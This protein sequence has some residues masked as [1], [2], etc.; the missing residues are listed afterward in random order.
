M[1]RLRAT[2]FL[3]AVGLL[4]LVLVAH[5]EPQPLLE[6]APCPARPS[7]AYHW[8]VKPFD[9]Q[10]P[11]RGAFGDPR[12]LALDQPFGETGPTASGSYE[13]H[14]G[15]DIV[16]YHA[17]VYP[18]VSGEVGRID[19]HGI[20]VFSS[21]G[22]EFIYEH[23]LGNVVI[24]QQVVAGHTVLGWTHR[25]LNHVHFG[26]IDV[27][28]HRYQ[29]ALAPGHLEPYAD[30]TTPRAIALDISNDGSPHL[31]NGGVV[32]KQDELAIEAL[33]P[34]AIPVPGPF[35]GMPQTPALV[36][37]RLRSGEEW[38]AWHIASDFR[39]SLPTSP[40]WTVYSAGTYQNFPGFDHRLFW[41]TAGRYLFRVSLDPSTLSPGTYAL[42]ARVG[43]V[44]G[45][46]STTTWP[47]EI[48]G[49]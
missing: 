39:Q 9:R 41:G 17:A 12:T 37:W 47:I 11:I 42:E 3:L 23:L 18:V 24:G 34:P 21:C 31:T 6:L 5:R 33:D 44:R 38:G 35:A 20:A 15:V 45:N 27:D 22:R 8:P 46:S 26:E 1:S 13:F 49:S 28:R 29:N 43:D 30:H 14:N 19:H 32:G 4:V 7:F 2:T 36:E 40:Y 10:H 16:A 48:S 25:P